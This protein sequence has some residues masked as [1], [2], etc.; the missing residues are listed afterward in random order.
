M[1][2]SQFI[3]M[4]SVVILCSLHRCGI[5]TSRTQPPVR[6]TV[7][8]FDT[9]P[10]Y[11]PKPRDSVVIRYVTETLPVVQDGTADTAGVDSL[12]VTIPITSNTYEGDGWR[13]HVSGFRPRLDSL[14]LFPERQTVTIRDPPPA[15]KA[16]DR[17]TLGVQA[18]Y[19][20]TPRGMQPYI[21]V[22]LTWRFRF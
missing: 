9:V 22:G 10:V 8:V 6:D 3:L 4:L 12:P 19:G 1:K 18:G 15:S 11:F 14:V 7:T 17:W 21:G 2:N 5:G 13:A 16:S 20:I